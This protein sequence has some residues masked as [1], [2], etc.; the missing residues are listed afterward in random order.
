[1]TLARHTSIKTWTNRGLA[2]VRDA[3]D[4]R[5]NRD[6][7]DTCIDQRPSSARHGS[8]FQSAVVGR[9]DDQFASSG[10]FRLVIVPFGFDRIPT[11]ASILNGID[12]C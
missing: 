6:R 5:R 8:T 11:L 1:M 9:S 10:S 3:R 12:D 2:I 4:D 7:T